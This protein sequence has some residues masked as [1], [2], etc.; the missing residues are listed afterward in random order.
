MAEKGRYGSGCALS[1]VLCLAQL[2]LPATAALSCSRCLLQSQRA[3]C[4][5]FRGELQE[6]V[7]L[8]S[9][10]RC[11]FCT[12]VVPL[13]VPGNC[14]QGAP[15]RKGENGVLKESPALTAS[16]ATPTGRMFHESCSVLRLF[17]DVSGGGDPA[18]PLSPE[19]ET[20]AD[21]M[22]KSWLCNSL[23][24]F[25]C[26]LQCHF[27]ALFPPYAP[28]CSDAVVYDCRAHVVKEARSGSLE[29]AELGGVWRV[30]P[31]VCQRRPV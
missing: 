7:P 17:A 5:E 27:I 15:V 22:G 19:T 23:E 29:M 16:C 14:F 8:G 26:P 25:P 2:S 12:I 24:S 31:A 1:A 3:P 30:V 11:K 28:L 18:S 6:G 13:H 20:R 9:C 4:V 21:G 10:T